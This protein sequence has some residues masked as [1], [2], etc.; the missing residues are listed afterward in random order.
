[1]NSLVSFCGTTIITISF[2]NTNSYLYL[3]Q[4]FKILFVERVTGKSVSVYGN[5]TRTRKN[6]GK[7]FVNFTGNTT[8]FYYYCICF[9]QYYINC[10]DK[11]FTSF[12]CIKTNTVSPKPNKKSFLSHKIVQT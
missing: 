10:S 2:R 11:G 1:M 4:S 6:Y 7:L 9:I 5:S 12:K 3:C 8:L